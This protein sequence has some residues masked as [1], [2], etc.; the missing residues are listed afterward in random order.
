MHPWI[1]R[2]ADDALAVCWRRVGNVLVVRWRYFKNG[3]MAD[4]VVGCLRGP[5]HLFEGKSRVTCHGSSYPPHSQTRS[6]RLELDGALPGGLEE[7][8][9]MLIRP[10]YDQ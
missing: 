4:L 3:T 1:R 10:R 6:S 7:H 8:A 2:S 9:T 5:D